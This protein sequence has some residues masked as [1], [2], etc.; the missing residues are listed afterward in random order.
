MQSS[1]CGLHGNLQTQTG[2]SEAEEVHLLFSRVQRQQAL[3]HCTPTL[4]HLVRDA[5]GRHGNPFPEGLWV[6]VSW[7]LEVSSADLLCELMLQDFMD[8]ELS[9]IISSWSRSHWQLTVEYFRS[10]LVR[11]ESLELIELL[12]VQMFAEA[13]CLAV[14]VEDAPR[15]NSLIWICENCWIFSYK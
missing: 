2:S 3:P 7:R 8:E 15:L 10:G 6:K 4:Q 9:F 14:D 12:T 13:V 5:A 1:R 11:T